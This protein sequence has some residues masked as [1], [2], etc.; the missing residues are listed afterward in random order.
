MILFL[1]LQQIINSLINA[2]P[3]LG[4]AADYFYSCT[5]RLPYKA[6]RQYLSFGFAEQYKEDNADMWPASWKMGGGSFNEP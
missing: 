3:L 4:D 6:N 1:S 2:V 5:C